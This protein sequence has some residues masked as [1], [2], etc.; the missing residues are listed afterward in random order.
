MWFGWFR[1]KK[2]PARLEGYYES[3]PDLR[4]IVRT[5]LSLQADRSQH[6]TS[7]R[8]I[9]GEVDLLN[10]NP[11]STNGGTLTAD[12]HRLDRRLAKL[13]DDRK[14]EALLKEALGAARG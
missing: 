4:L 9:R 10:G 11:N 1:R 2:N 8:D 12:I 5:L 6:T 7:I 13:E 3:H 14:R